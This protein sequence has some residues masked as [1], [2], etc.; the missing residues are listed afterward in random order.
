[1]ND[2]SVRDFQKHS[3]PT[4]KNFDRSS[5]LGPW[6]VTADDIPDPTALTLR[7]RLNGTT[8]QS[9]GTDML[10]YDIPRY[11]AYLSQWTELLSG[12]VISTGTPAGVGQKRVPPLWLK[13][14]DIVEVEIEEIG[15]LRNRVIPE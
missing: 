13:P 12:D 5:S 6:M 7:T 10:I 2:G 11:I 3:V 14:G 8:V 15:V 1:M 9:S 4:G